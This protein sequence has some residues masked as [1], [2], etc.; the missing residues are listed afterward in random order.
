VQTLRHVRSF[1]DHNMREEPRPGLTGPGYNI[2]F[3]G[4]EDL[5]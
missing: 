4:R 5:L 3:L 1:Q 2:S